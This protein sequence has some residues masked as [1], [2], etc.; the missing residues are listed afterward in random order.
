MPG[1]STGSPRQQLITYIRIFGTGC[2]MGARSFGLGWVVSGTG[3]FKSGTGGG[4]PPDAFRRDHVYD[5]GILTADPT[6]YLS[7]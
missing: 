7:V 5:V 3:G 4:Q 2:M 1:R 6:A